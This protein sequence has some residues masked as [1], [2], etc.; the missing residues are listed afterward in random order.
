FYVEDIEAV[1]TK[2]VSYGAEILQPLQQKPQGKGYLKWA[3]ISAW[4]SLSHTLIE[5][6]VQ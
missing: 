6:E 2:A 1:L 3:T 4:G 5:A